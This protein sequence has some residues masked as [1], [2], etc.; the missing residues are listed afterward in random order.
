MLRIPRL[1]AILASLLVLPETGCSKDEG[2][3]APSSDVWDIEADG[4]PRFVST[5]YIELDRIHRISRFRSSCGHDYSDAFEHCRSMKHY[6]EPYGD[7]DWSTL[8]IHSPVA[9]TITRVDVEWAGTKLELVAR[10]Y[11]AFRLSIFHVT[12]APPGF[13]VGDDVT[14]GQLLGTHVGT[15]TMSDISVIVNDPT[16]QGRM[17]SYF[18]VM[19]DGV[20]QTYQ[21]RGVLDRDTLVISKALRDANPLTCNGDQFVSGDPLEPWVTLD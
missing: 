15:Q 11:P 20:F 19:T 21:A 2:G 7:T 16:R 12:V 3:P 6:F 18:Q 13:A 5:D 10:A 1:A 4:I 8:Q 17:V 14:E 9:G